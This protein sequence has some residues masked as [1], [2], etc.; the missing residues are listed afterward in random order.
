LGRALDP[1]ES[2]ANLQEVAAWHRRRMR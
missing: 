1:P 2:F